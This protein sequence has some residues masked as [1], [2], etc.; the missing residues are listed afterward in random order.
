MRLSAQVVFVRNATYNLHRYIHTLKADP[1]NNRDN[2]SLQV[3]L[4]G[5]TSLKPDWDMPCQG[6]DHW[7]CFT[8]S[9]GTT[10]LPAVYYSSV[11]LKMS[12]LSKQGHKTLSQLWHARV[13]EPGACRLRDDLPCIGSSTYGI[14]LTQTWWHN[15]EFIFHTASPT[16]PAS[17][18][19]RPFLPLS[20]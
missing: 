4:R 8:V 16:G 1:Q 13:H 18:Q 6:S 3:H 5:H 15:C 2:G 14:A 12:S 20:M 11:P 10:V 9:V 19:S 17:L 7:D